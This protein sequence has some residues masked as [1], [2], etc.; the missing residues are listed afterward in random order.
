MS[1]GKTVAICQFG[2]E[3]VTGDDGNMS[4]SGGEAHVVVVDRDLPFDDFIVEVSNILKVDVG[5]ISFKYFLPGNRR[6]PITVS[7]DK[8]LQRMVDFHADSRTID[9]YVQKVDNRFGSRSTR[10][11]VADLGT[12]VVATDAVAK[13]N[14]MKQKRLA[15]KPTNKRR[16]TNAA[17]ASGVPAAQMASSAR[18][19]RQR[20]PS[21]TNNVINRVIRRAEATASSAAPVSVHTVRRERFGLVLGDVD[22]R[23]T[24]NVGNVAGAHFVAPVTAFDDSM[25]LMPN[26]VAED[27]AREIRSFEANV[28]SSIFDHFGMDGSD[29]Q[30]DLSNLWGNLITGVGQEFDNANG[31]RDALSK[32]AI[33][34]GFAYSFIKNESNR[35]TVKCNGDE[36]S[37]RIHASRTSTKQNFMI[38]NMIDE[39]ACEG[40]ISREN[41]PQATQRWV[42][43]IIKDKLRDDPHY[44]TKDIVRDIKRDYGIVLDYHKVWRGK[45]VAQKE[46]HNLQ[47]E[48]CRQLPWFCERILETNPRSVAT[49]VATGDSRF[50]RLFVAFYASLY[51]FEHGCRPLLFIDRISLKVNNQWK[52]LAAIAIDAENGLFPV[53]FAAVEEENYESWNWFL[54]QLRYTLNPA[55]AITF[56]SDGKR[57]LGTALQKNFADGYH[58]Y[59][60]RRLIED[61]KAQ[62]SDSLSQQ[63]RDKMVDDLERAAQVC[64]VEEFN[65]QVENIRSISIDAAD[66]VLSSG[67]ENWSNALFRGLRYGHLSSDL[68]KSLNSWIP[69]KH[70]SSIIQIVEAIRCKMMEVITTRQELSKSWEGTLVPSIEKE[71]QKEMTKAR[72][73]SALCS[74]GSVFEV[75]GN[76]VDAVNI[77]TWECTCRKWQVYSLPCMHAI[78]VFNRINKPVHNYCFKYFTIDCYRSTY[79]GS[80]HPILG[81]GEFV[82]IN[83]ICGASS[84][85]PPAIPVPGRRRRIRLDRMK[86]NRKTFHCSR[87]KGVG[88]NKAT[89]YVVV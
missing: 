39:H 54:V 49:S 84:Y 6:I 16:N 64:T 2:G 36:C 32:Y 86:P 40:W 82:D 60:L 53:A 79:S 17:A 73:L 65:V 70:E 15:T 1:G 66:W 20:R 68:P 5:A 33:A 28:G 41:H 46:L 31:F 35:V 21:S 48:S 83:S 25:Q 56:V 42:A 38:K 62:L 19:V 12:S 43:N 88:H 58:S 74:S 63:D 14:G 3:F 47:V 59:C 24:S 67:P 69:L 72:S 30:L 26:V 44:K 23:E 4:Y 22:N 37:W 89:C 77:E 55:R 27:D 51:G 29:R 34:R 10:S 11:D 85:P 76:S 13:K 57:G 50:H 9:V 18:N 61:F 8:D 75:R 78:A 81:E 71:L 87:C 7:G 52:L 45:E 80:I